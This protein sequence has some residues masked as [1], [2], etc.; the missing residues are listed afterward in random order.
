MLGWI[1]GAIEN[2]K[3]SPEQRLA[4][5]AQKA[6]DGRAVGVDV[7]P[8]SA[9]DTW[10]ECEDAKFKTMQNPRSGPASV[11]AGKKSAEA[12]CVLCHGAS[13]KGDGVAAPPLNPRPSDWTS[14]N[15]KNDADGALFCKISINRGAMP[16]WKHLPANERWDLV[17]YI[18]S[19]QGITGAATKLNAQSTPQPFVAQPPARNSAHDAMAAL[20]ERD[21]NARLSYALQDE[22][23]RVTRSFFQGFDKSGAASWNVACA[24]GKT[25]SILINN[26]ARGSSRI[27]DC[28][29]LKALANVECFKKFSDQ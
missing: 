1:V 9:Q 13:G 21:R 6:T 5:K 29:V 20:S 26:D 14:L 11:A 4:E 18:R 25:L 23:C 27:L 8:H 12:N 7:T 19:L 17:N 16:P 2:T 10:K 22:S 15:V 28:A 3:K 24:N